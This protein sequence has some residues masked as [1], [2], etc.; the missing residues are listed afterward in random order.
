MKLIILATLVASALAANPTFPTTWN[1][2]YAS[3]LIL[4]SLFP[5]P[6]LHNKPTSRRNV[7]NTTHI[8]T[9]ILYSGKVVHTIP[10][11]TPHVV[12]KHPLNAKYKHK[13]K[14]VHNTLTAQTI[15][16]QCKL[17]DK[18]LLTITKP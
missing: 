11:T 4:V 18:Q 15:K 7:S 8:H 14:W 6:P 1:S 2:D 5:P 12:Q 13:V 3:K 9:Y 17:V 10:V 16:L